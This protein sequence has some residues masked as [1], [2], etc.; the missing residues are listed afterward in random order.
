MTHSVCCVATSSVTQV[1]CDKTAEARIMQFSLK[2]S[3]IA[4][5]L[6]L[7]DLMMK[8]KGGPLDREAETRVGWILTSGCYISETVRYIA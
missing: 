1:Y 5:T 3:S 8:F 6:C 2:P 7:P 4:L